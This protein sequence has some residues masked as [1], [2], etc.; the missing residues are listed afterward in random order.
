MSTSVASVTSHFPDAEN[1]FTTTTSGSVA[2]GA[3][4]VGLNS[5]AGYTNGE[6][7][8]FVIDPSD[9]TKKQTFTGIIDT[10]G[11]QVT[12][13]VWT[14]GTNVAHS[15]GA[16]VVDYATA[17]HI[18]MMSKGIKVEHNQDG[19]HDEALIVSRTEDTTPVTGDYLLTSDVSAS[20]ALKKVQIGNVTPY[21]A[22]KSLLTIDS[23]PYKFSV[24][25]SASQTGISD[26]VVT[27]VTFDTEKFDTNNNFAASTY[28]APV[29]G[30][31]QIN[32]YLHVQ[33][34]AN[35]GIAGNIYLHKNGASIQEGGRTYPSA[36]AGNMID[37]AGNISHLVQ[38]T[39]GDTL[40]IYAL[41]NATSGTITVIG[42]TAVS[43]FSGFLVSQT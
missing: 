21:K 43:S 5:T 3:S 12:G 2:S 18:A 16:T 9:T 22:D 36:V 10:S 15:T 42:G 19:T 17:T 34:A 8:V 23:N 6:P 29:S 11:N 24:H 41:F 30:F 25:K 32:A 38:L 1:G 14:A 31:Y 13:V 4:T 37:F 20:N 28:T 27:K 26:N 33:S 40:D 35:D 39:A 7:V